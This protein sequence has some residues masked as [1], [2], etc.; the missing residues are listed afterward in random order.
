MSDELMNTRELAAYLGIHEKQV[1]ALVKTG[2]MP[3]TRVTGKWIFPKKMIDV[4]IEDN[5]R[6]GIEQAREKSGRIAGALLASGSTTF[7]IW[8][9]SRRTSRHWSSISFIGNWVLSWGAAT[10]RGSAVLR[11]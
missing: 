4:W 11:T 5:A 1:Y 10:R 9:G 6:S 7:R 3:A 2:R 8:T